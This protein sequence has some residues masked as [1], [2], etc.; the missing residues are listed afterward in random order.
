MSSVRGA[1]DL[2]VDMCAYVGLI[3][4]IDSLRV[5]QS[6]KLGILFCPACGDSSVEPSVTIKV[7]CVSKLNRSLPHL[8]LPTPTPCSWRDDIS[9]NTANFP[10]LLITSASHSFS[11]PGERSTQFI[12]PRLAGKL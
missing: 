10:N 8:R 4:G 3:S 7:T 12:A 1:V 5:L 9:A 2:L 6:L 11:V